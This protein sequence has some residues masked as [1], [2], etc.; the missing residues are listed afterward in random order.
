VTSAAT[1]TLPAKDRARSVLDAPV[2]LA[3]AAAALAVPLAFLGYGTDLD[4]PNVLR[5]GRIWLDTGS[6]ELSRGPG[7][8]LH[9][10]ATA[11]LDRAGGS[12]LVDLAGLAFAAL[13]LWSI[14]RLL[15]FD[16]SP[17]AGPATLV[18]AA[19]PWFWV[20]ASSL[21]DF[22]WALALT[23]AGAV[24]A[25]TGRRWVAGGAFGLAV[26]CRMSS[27]LLVAAWLLAERTGQEPRPPWRDTARTGALA[28]GIA[29]AGFVPSWLWADRT[30]AFL[31]NEF[32]FQGL[33]VHLGRWAVKNIAVLGVVGMLVVAAAS[34]V[35][36]RVVR[37]WP[38]SV[39]VRFAVVAVVAEELLFLRLPFKPVHLLPVVAG[40]AL[41]AGCTPGA[42]RRWVWGLVAAGA[43][44]AVVGVSLAE[45]DRV[46][47]ADGG[48]LSV[49]VVPGVLVND[50]R[51]RLDDRAAGPWPDP[52]D[53]AGFAA[54]TE[55]AEEL[56]DCQ[57]KSWR[58]RD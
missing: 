44:A 26:A 2:V 30:L 15:T 18:L 7:A 54:A 23:L 38:A 3:A 36:A 14:H 27:V 37:R 29:V 52:A 55:R 19:N 32:E 5:A 50:V 25:R 34:P 43:V 33:A 31:D 35:L 45:P 48:R 49:G 13:A 10:L 6:Y 56:F 21:G 39:V 12:V 20:A 47:D 58:A 9:E 16:G 28:A 24:A 1:A 42:A 11:I 4:V 57:A 17:H 8:P 51:C 46:N 40:L 22:V 53:P 41:L